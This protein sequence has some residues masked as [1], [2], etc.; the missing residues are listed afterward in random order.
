MQ[1]YAISLKDSLTNSQVSCGELT[2]YKKKQTDFKKQIEQLT[3]L[4]WRKIIKST[5]RN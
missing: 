5:K 3:S 4:F 1:Q 2:N